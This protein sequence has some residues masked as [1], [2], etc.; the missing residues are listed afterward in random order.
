MYVTLQLRNDCFFHHIN[1]NHYDDASSMKMV[2]MAGVMKRQRRILVVESL[3]QFSFF[4][5]NHKVLINNFSF[6]LL[7]TH[8]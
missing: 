6:M 7:L 2:M 1:A 3:N 8:R 4:L 5:V